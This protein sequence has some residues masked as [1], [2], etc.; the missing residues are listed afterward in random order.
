MLLYKYQKFKNK[1][2]SLLLT[3]PLIVHPL[4]RAAPP[5]VQCNRGLIDP[6]AVKVIFREHALPAVPESQVRLA[7]I[8]G[9]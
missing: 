6:P 8:V 2:R 1:V 3:Y 7:P 4:S 9:R 5:L